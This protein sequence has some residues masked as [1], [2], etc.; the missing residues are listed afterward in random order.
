MG[1]PELIV[2]KNS[3]GSLTRCVMV[4][5]ISSTSRFHGGLSDTETSYAKFESL[6]PRRPVIVEKKVERK[7][8]ACCQVINLIAVVSL[9]RRK[10]GDF[11]R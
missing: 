2:Q 9:N 5:F 4:R 3:L 6:I 11:C 10:L 1:T 8:N 7:G